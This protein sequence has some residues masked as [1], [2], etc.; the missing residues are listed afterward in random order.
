[1]MRKVLAAMEKMHQLWDVRPRTTCDEA[2][3]DREHGVG[4]ERLDCTRVCENIG[5]RC[6]GDPGV[7][8][9]VRHGKAAN[10]NIELLNY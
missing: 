4:A 5:A 10:S 7:V 9:L 6:P 3:L 8:Q 2:R 1:M